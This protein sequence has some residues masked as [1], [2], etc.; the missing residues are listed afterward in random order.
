MVIVLKKQKAT[1]GKELLR[2]AYTDT[3]LLIDSSTPGDRIYDGFFLYALTTRN[4]YSSY[5]DNNVIRRNK[6][7]KV[8][9]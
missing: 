3:F 9:L 7:F 6:L 8:V 2:V 4:D 5:T 1:E